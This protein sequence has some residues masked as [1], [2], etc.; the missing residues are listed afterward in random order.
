MEGR[1][2][3][4]RVCIQ[5]VGYAFKISRVLIQDVDPSF[6]L[7]CVCL[8]EV[9]WLPVVQVFVAAL[10]CQSCFCIK[11][12]QTEA[13]ASAVI[14][15][16]HCSRM[17]T[18]RSSSRLLGG[19]CLSACWDTPPPSWTPRVWAWTPPPQPDPPTSTQLHLQVTSITM[20]TFVE[21]FAV[22]WNMKT[23]CRSYRQDSG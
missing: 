8:R 20:V 22:D 2:S 15:R 5:A 16:M 10:R 7:Y 11:T 12:I 13:K 3:S 17:H 1:H 9:G 14:T 23:S 6:S 21:L 19:V 18:P 4:C